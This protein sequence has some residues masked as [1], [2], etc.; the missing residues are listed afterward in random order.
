MANPKPSSISRRDFL[1][2]SGAASLGLAL[3]ACGSTQEPS[4]TPRL[5][6]TPRSTATPRPTQ[7][8]TPT[9]TP[10]RTPTATRTSTLT[11]TPRPYQVI[12]SG[13]FDDGAVVVGGNP[14]Y[15]NNLHTQGAKVELIEYEGRGKVMK[16]S[17][18]GRSKNEGNG[19]FRRGYYDWFNGP[20]PFAET[21]PAPCAISCD[22]LTSHQLISQNAKPAASLLS[23]HS[24]EISTGKPEFA[25]GLNIGAGGEYLGLQFHSRNRDGWITCTKLFIADIFINLM[26]VIEMDG[27]VLPYMDGKLA[28]KDSNQAPVIYPGFEVGLDDGHSGLYTSSGENP[29]PDFPE[30]AY[31]LVDNFQIIK[32]VS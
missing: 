26:L 22:V 4:A 3:S 5:T 7:T 21:I 14:K 8:S 1:K 20:Y 23:F 2:L 29:T 13:N 18:F 15:W 19:W 11:P 9:V 25:A 17:V 16:A 31:V 24:R 6:N 12:F 27:R 30:G 10:T 32:Y 28:L